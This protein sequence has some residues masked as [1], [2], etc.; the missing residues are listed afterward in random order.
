MQ[1]DI[2]ALGNWLAG[3]SNARLNPHVRTDTALLIV[4]VSTISP[5]P[6]VRPAGDVA[7]LVTCSDLA[8]HPTQEMAILTRTWARH[9]AT[10]DPAKIPFGP[11]G[12]HVKICS[13]LWSVSGCASSGPA[14]TIAAVSDAQFG[15][16][17]PAHGGDVLRQPLARKYGGCANI[18]TERQYRCKRPISRSGCF[19]DSLRRKEYLAARCGQENLKV[20]LPSHTHS[21]ALEVSAYGQSALLP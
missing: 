2:L 21:V 6:V 16:Q 19:D 7:P 17:H 12:G 4:Q 1:T 8:S 10:T 14:V 13:G 5:A 20:R 18:G 9:V 11:C 3:I 15:G